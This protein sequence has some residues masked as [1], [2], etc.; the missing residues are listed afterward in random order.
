MTSGNGEAK[1]AVSYKQLSLWL[2]GILIVFCGSFVGYVINHQDN[3][4]NQ[5]TTNVN[6][7]AASVAKV[8][9]VQD[10]WVNIQQNLSELT[11]EKN[12]EHEQI[13]ERLARL[14]TMLKRP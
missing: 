9:A 1:N 4:I 5:L 12:L 6:A 13:K 7:L 14:E 10:S 11:K 8:V 2:V 3:E